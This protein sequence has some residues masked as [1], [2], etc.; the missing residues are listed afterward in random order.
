[1]DPFPE[2][3]GHDGRG[4]IRGRFFCGNVGPA[5]RKHRA[6]P[7]VAVVQT[8]VEPEGRQSAEASATESRRSLRCRCV[9]LA[10]SVDARLRWRTFSNCLFWLCFRIGRSAWRRR[11]PQELAATNEKKLGSVRRVGVCH[12][13]IYLQ[14]RF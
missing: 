11:L 12:S 8:F 3:S 10:T 1:T 5:G 14:K 6:N 7:R 13:D 4:A 9:M 2:Q